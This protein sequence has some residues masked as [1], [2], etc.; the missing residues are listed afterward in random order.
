MNAGI[1]MWT[2]VKTW[3]YKTMMLHFVVYMRCQWFLCMF[4]WSVFNEEYPPITE[5][6]ALAKWA[7]DPANTAWME[8]K[9]AKSSS[10]LKNAIVNDTY[11][12]VERDCAFGA[13]P[14]YFLPCCFEEADTAEAFLLN[15]TFC[16]CLTNLC[17]I[18]I[19][20][21]STWPC[22]PGPDDVIYDD[23]PRENSDSNTG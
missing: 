4:F 19:I 13:I 18:K 1:H 2:S 11:L 3:N 5:E 20:H 12:P 7:A 9:R 15:I 17:I 23:V 8:S 10:D 16:L 22:A 14:A 21:S 6:D